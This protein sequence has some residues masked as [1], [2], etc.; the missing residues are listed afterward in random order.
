MTILQTKRFEKVYKRLHP[1]Q[2]AEANKVLETVIKNP[3]I[4]E[5]KKGDLSW[6][7]VYKFTMVNQLTLLGYSVEEAKETILTFVDM[8]PHENFYRNLKTGGTKRGS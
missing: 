4:G 2:L 3:G 6:L 5:Q 1:N 7:R 8:G